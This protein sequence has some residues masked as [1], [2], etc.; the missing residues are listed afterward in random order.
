MS[1]D[2]S[3][4]G[5]RPRAK[6]MLPS[7]SDVVREL[8]ADASADPSQ[9][10]KV[11]RQVCAEELGRVKLGKEAVALDVL[12]E[13]ARRI[14]DPTR[15]ASE[16]REDSGAFAFDMPTG[17][18][19]SSGPRASAARAP[20]ESEDPFNEASA[21]VDLGWDSDAH[22]S[23]LSNRNPGA[24]DAVLSTSASLETPSRS[25]EPSFEPRKAGSS[26]VSGPGDETLSSLDRDAHGVDLQKVV[27]Q[28][29]I[30][31]AASSW[32]YDEE[33]TERLDTRSIPAARDVLFK[34]LPAKRSPLLPMLMIIGGVVALGA[35]AYLVV[36]RRFLQETE[37]PTGVLSGRVSRPRTKLGEIS[38]SQGATTS[39]PNTRPAVAVLEPPPD[40]AKKTSASSASA[41]PAAS[42]ATR[43][44]PAPARPVTASEPSRNTSLETPSSKGSARAGALASPDWAGKPAVYVVHF[45]SYKDR[46]NAEKDAARLAQEFGRTGHAVSIDLGSKGVWY[47]AVL[48]DFGSA[49]EAQDFR[50]ELAL[51]KT[52][53]LG[54]VYHLV[55]P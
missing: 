31:P 12:V 45:T 13:R 9:L 30:P 55:A 35:T 48:G 32:G 39:S 50:D 25:I 1:D 44:S 28:T 52:P 7:V 27:L 24:A 37:R 51:K 47:R 23:P 3:A 42:V 40:T 16:R 29:Q 26:E 20:A 11:A 43:P 17:P 5:D 4:A 10:F 38:P 8:Q 54:L 53:R 18:I 34:A 6:R 33:A 21:P 19:G 15:E 46:A 22:D 41:Q 14:L 36:G 49:A 2:G